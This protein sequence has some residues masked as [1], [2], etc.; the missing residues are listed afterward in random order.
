MKTKTSILTHLITLM[1][2][3]SSGFIFLF[4]NN[5]EDELELNEINTNLET[6][7]HVMN[8]ETAGWH[9]LSIYDDIDYVGY[10]VD[11]VYATLNI[12][13]YNYETYEYNEG[14]YYIHFK[15]RFGN[16]HGI[17]QNGHAKL[18]SGNLESH[19]YPLVNRTLV[20]FI[21]ALPNGVG[22]IRI[23]F[24]IHYYFV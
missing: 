15:D 13:F 22:N 3:L 8:I 11:Y 5:H 1:I 14:Y 6:P 2:I 7:N 24:Y 16:D 23:E 10:R 21:I 9:N 18:N 17:A 19:I 12:S 20:M 4:N